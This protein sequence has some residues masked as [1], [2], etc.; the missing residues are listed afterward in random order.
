MAG[1]SPGNSLTRKLRKSKE[2]RKKSRRRRSKLSGNRR[3]ERFL[4]YALRVISRHNLSSTTSKAWA[5]WRTRYSPFL[6]F[7]ISRPLKEL[8]SKKIWKFNSE[9]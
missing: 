9:F 2:F 5:L 4:K 3:K 1:V 8:N 7:S 6:K